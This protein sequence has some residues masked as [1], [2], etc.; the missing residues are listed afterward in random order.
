[1]TELDLRTDRHVGAGPSDTGARR[2]GLAHEEP[3]TRHGFLVYSGG[4]ELPDDN[5][6]G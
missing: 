2:F 4:R 6:T 1:V 3:Q 5:R